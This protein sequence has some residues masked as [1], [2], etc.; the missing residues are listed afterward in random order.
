MISLIGLLKDFSISKNHA[1]I[2]YANYKEY[3]LFIK[4]DNF[5]RSFIE[6]KLSDVCISSIEINRKLSS[7]SVSIFV[8]KPSLVMGINSSRLY[9]LRDSLSHE[10]SKQFS[11][12]EVVINVFEVLNPDS[13]S[14]LL[15]DF[16]REQLEK[17]V[18]FRRAIKSAVV[19]AQKSGVKG[20]KVQ[21]SGRLNGAEIARTEWIRE[22][23]VPLHTLKANIDYCSFKAPVII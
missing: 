6:S 10:L 12:R 23:Q 13:N 1:S 17:R 21:V 19:K 7:L 11:T 9:E 2:W 8:A 16:I 5:V 15:A 14:K 3:V 22:G 18:P 4:E 20:V